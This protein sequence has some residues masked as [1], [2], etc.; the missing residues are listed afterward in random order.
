MENGFFIN[1]DYYSDIGELIEDIINYE[2][3]KLE[4]IPDDWQIKVDIA[5]EEPIFKNVNIDS[6]IESMIN[7]ILDAEWER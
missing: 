7:D 1:E 6:Y 3:E 5:K 4:D 2:C